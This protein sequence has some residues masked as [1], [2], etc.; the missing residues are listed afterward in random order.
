MIIENQIINKIGKIVEMDEMWHFIQNK[1]KKCWIWLAICRVT[2]LIF[3]PFTGSRGAK[4]GTAFFETVKKYC[5]Q[6]TQFNTDYWEPYTKFVPFNQ[7]YQ[8]KD[9]TYTVEGYNA[10][11]R[12]DLQRL[13]RRTRAYSKSQE[14]LDVSLYLYIEKHNRLKLRQL[15]RLS[16]R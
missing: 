7:H 10:N 2:K 9:E 14:M 13:T 3:P 8:G 12:D 5:P 11:F 1:G 6:N 16:I 4:T 15:D